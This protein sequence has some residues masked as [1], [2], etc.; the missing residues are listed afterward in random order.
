MSH[1]D[2]VECLIICEQIAD[3]EYTASAFSAPSNGA[4]EDVLPY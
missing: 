3:Y 4:M 2:G 1:P